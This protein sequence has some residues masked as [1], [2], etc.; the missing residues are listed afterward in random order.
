MQLYCYRLVRRTTGS[1]LTCA[2]LALHGPHEVVGPL[3]AVQ[4]L[5]Q[6]KHIIIKHE[7][8]QVEGAC[9][10]TQDDFY[11][12]KDELFVQQYAWLYR[13]KCVLKSDWGVGR[14][15]CFGLGYT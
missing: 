7:M 12:E 13:I 8:D 9:V 2:A 3:L 10:D 4:G 15:P 11:T 14:Y 5:Q 1:S 6:V